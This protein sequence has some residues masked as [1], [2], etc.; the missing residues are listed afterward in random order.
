MSL[1]SQWVVLPQPAW[2]V[3]LALTAPACA[4]RN[5]I[6]RPFEDTFDRSQIGANYHNTGG[7]YQIA[8]GKLNVQD[9]YNKPL[10]LKRELPRD[11]VV[12]VDV[13]SKTPDGDIKL[14]L[15]GDGE[16]FATTKGAYLASSY[17]FIFGG[18]SNSISVL[19]R[20]DE[21]GHDRKERH[22]IKVK[23]GQRYHFK[24]RRKGPRIDWEIDGKPFLDMVDSAPLEGSHHAYL[25]F[26]DWQ[27]DLYFDNLRITPLK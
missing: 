20:L 23:V 25:G 10:W 16:S 4:K 13:M 11:A 6:K 1:R 26:N 15:W 21:H 17:V 24:I 3:L 27:S 5:P 19:A 7:P 8:D 22:D 2:V 18:W 9:A 14:E 12:E